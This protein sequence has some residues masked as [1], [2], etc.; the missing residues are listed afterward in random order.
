MTPLTVLSRLALVALATLVLSH[1]A[2]AWVLGQP[3]PPSAG[4][5]VTRIETSVDE[6]PPKMREAYI[7]G[8]QEELVAHG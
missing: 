3:K 4:L 2:E 7:V 6:M 1:G 5:A 8:I